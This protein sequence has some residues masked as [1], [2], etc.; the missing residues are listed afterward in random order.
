MSDA[1]STTR[2]DVYRTVTDTIVAAIEAGAGEFV[3]P[4]HGASARIAKP[5]NAHT[6]MEYHGINVIALWAE[7]CLK[8]YQSGYW[9]SYRQWQQA[10]A[11]VRQGEKGATVVFFKR[12]NED[13][14]SAPA[15]RDAI[16]RVPLVARASRVFNADQ[17]T[18]WEP[19]IP[20]H[21]GDPVKVLESV[22]TFVA[23]SRA[24]VVHGADA[25]YDILA[26]VIEMP[27]PSR[28]TGSPTSSASEAWHATLLH[29]LVHWSGAK[30]RLD[31]K[32]RDISRADLAREELI[33]EIGAAFLC[34]D[35]GVTNSPRP[36]H[37]AYVANWLQLLKNDTRAVFQASSAASKAA[38]YLH[39]VAAGGDW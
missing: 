29:E 10:G 38:T 33:A 23:G 2:F 3:M 36:D 8:R 1:E 13:S 12:L 20:R 16:S 39:D 24:K 15:D 14:D 34:A 26:D 22:A 9:A 28:F 21:N 19:P 30:H 5:E 7:A 11:Q 4:W 17:V 37:A 18:G 27:T 35:L 6:R 31:R 32:I 25:R